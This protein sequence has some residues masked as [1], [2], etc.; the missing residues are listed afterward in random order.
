MQGVRMTGNDRLTTDDLRE[1]VD[2]HTGGCT[3]AQLRGVVTELH[4]P[5]H[6]RAC[7]LYRPVIAKNIYTKYIYS[8]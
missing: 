7:L 6:A 1:G 5:L 2:G 8:L 3:E 4:V